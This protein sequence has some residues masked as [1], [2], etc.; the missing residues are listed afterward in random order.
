M[1]LKIWRW[2]SAAFKAESFG[3]WQVRT[4]NREGARI[5]RLVTAHTTK[6]N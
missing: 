5:M 2:K 4:A 6:A 1:L 3:V